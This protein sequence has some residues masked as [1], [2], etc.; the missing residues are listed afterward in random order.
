[1]AVLYGFH[2]LQDAFDQ[3][4]VEVLPVVQDAVALAQAEH[5]RVTNEVVALFANRTTAYGAAVRTGGARRLQPQDEFARSL[6]TRRR[7]SGHRVEFP[8]QSAGDALAQTYEASVA[9]TVEDVNDNLAEMQAADSV[10]IREHLMGALFAN[11]SWQFDDDQH[12]PLTIYG[13]ANGDAHTYTVDAA[14]IS[15]EQDNHYSAQSAVISDAANPYPGEREKLEHHPQNASA[16]VV[17]FIHA[18][19]RPATELL[20]G[21]YTYSDPNIS[22]GPNE[23]QLVGTAPTGVPGKII[24]YVDGVWVSVWG[25]MP[26]GFILTVALSAS[27]ALA[28]REWPYPVLQGFVLDAEEQHYPY[29]QRQYKRRAGFGAYDRVGASVRRIGNAAYAV[30]SGFATPMP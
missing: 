11:N 21:F 9:M 19:Q 29:L 5:N 6:P 1:M 17:S 4:A 12:G 2:S 13:L 7:P 23:P 25:G 22:P 3:A 8:L 20:T 24:G 15:Q 30:P 14:G 16:P 26:S 28:M 10:W 18:D 27:K